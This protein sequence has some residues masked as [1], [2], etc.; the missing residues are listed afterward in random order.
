MRKNNFRKLFAI[1]TIVCTLTVFMFGS[2]A[3]AAGNHPPVL[4]SVVNDIGG[5]PTGIQS[6]IVVYDQDNDTVG[7]TAYIDNQYAGTGF[8]YNAYYYGNVNFSISNANRASNPHTIT[9][10]LNDGKTTVTHTETF[11]TNW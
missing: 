3:Y 11:Y 9:I 2:M 6:V 1:L 10:I 8:V 4:V 7:C 5:D